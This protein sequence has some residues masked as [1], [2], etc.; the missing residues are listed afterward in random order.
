MNLR[1][2]RIGGERDY[3]R[4]VR[5]NARGRLTLEMPCIEPNDHAGEPTM[6]PVE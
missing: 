5:A 2:F 6:P 1:T 3:Y 4:N